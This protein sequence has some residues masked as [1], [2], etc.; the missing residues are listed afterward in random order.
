MSGVDLVHFRKYMVGE[1]ECCSERLCS[2]GTFLD[3]C[4]RRCAF[5]A[6][7]AR[8]ESVVITFAKFISFPRTT[9]K[10]ELIFE[11]LDTKVSNFLNYRGI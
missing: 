3:L 10:A 9:A 2:W 7:R 6:F 8:R 1:E 4:E 5:K 11:D